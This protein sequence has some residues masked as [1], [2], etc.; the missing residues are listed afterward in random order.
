MVKINVAQFAGE[1]SLPVA[2]LLEQLQAAGVAKQQ[3]TDPLTEQDKARLLE[4]L[5]SAHGSGSANSK[6]ITLTRRETTEIK[7]ADSTGKARTIQVEVRK[8]RVIAPLALTEVEQPA[9]VAVAPLI[10]PAV[11]QEAGSKKLNEQALVLRAEEA[12]GHVELASRQAA[13]V[14]VKKERVKRKAAPVVVEE[15]QAAAPVVTP[16]ATALPAAKPS[17]AEGTLHKPAPKPGDKI[18]RP[19]AKKGAK[20]ADKASPWDEAGHKK[21]TPAT[22]DI[23]PSGWTAG[24][25]RAGPRHHDKRPAQEAAGQH[26]FSL[27][28]EPVVHEVMVPETISVAELAQKNVGQGHRNY[29]GADESWYHGNDQ[30][31]AGSGNGDDRGGRAGP[32][33]QAG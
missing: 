6:K 29:Q 13:E 21:R 23:R 14:Q 12:R 7:K 9:A 10:E 3:E 33:C 20:T 15:V 5:R 27:P 1:L 4:H 30:S 31:G 2:L 18:I 17:L 8:K 26:A 16:V 22:T 28:T 25:G 11:T 19:T 32:H 24:R